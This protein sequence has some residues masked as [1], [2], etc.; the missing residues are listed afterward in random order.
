MFSAF[1]AGVF[2]PKSKLGVMNAAATVFVPTRKPEAPTSSH[3][4]SRKVT[5]T[6]DQSAP[7]KEEPAALDP[8]ESTA[9]GGEDTVEPAAASDVCKAEDALQEPSPSP[10]KLS[11]KEQVAAP[12]TADA[13]NA[14]TDTG[15][16]PGAEKTLVEV[17]AVELSSTSTTVPMVADNVNGVAHGSTEHPVPQSQD[18][19][20]PVSQQTLSSRASVDLTGAG[21]DG[22]GLYIPEGLLDESLHVGECCY[23]F[24]GFSVPG[25]KSMA[26]GTKELCSDTSQVLFLPLKCSVVR[27]Y[28][29]RSTV[30]SWVFEL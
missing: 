25:Q 29:S 22:G 15:E 20:P 7:A 10:Q 2:A 3:S 17:P 13:S 8:S 9:N 27:E 1:Q 24:F 14:D 26:I 19:Q 16:G 11:D 30:E 5:P 4:L 21:S 6:P 28:K 23:R 18:A 12:E